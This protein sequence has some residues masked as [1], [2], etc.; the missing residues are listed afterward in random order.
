MKARPLHLLLL[1]AMVLCLR[2]G[3]SGTEHIGP[4][5]FPCANL[6]VVEPNGGETYRVG[7]TLVLRWDGDSTVLQSII[8]CG[9]FSPDSGLN[10]VQVATG[11]IMFGDPRW[12]TIKWVI[13]DSVLGVPT[14]SDKCLARVNDF[15]WWDSLNDVSDACFR[16]SGR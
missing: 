8:A 14:V 7:D 12:P 6:C 4:Q 9:S 1:S 5:P 13:P 16:V 10:W 2:C 11:C 3:D 15:L